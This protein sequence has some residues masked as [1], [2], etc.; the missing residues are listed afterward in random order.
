[1]ARITERTLSEAGDEM[2][3]RYNARKAADKAHSPTPSTAPKPREKLAKVI[4]RAWLNRTWS[5]WYHWRDQLAVI[6]VFTGVA[7]AVARIKDGSRGW[8][9]VKAND[10]QYESSP[11][12][13]PGPIGR[14]LTIPEAHSSWAEEL[15]RF[16]IPPVPRQNTSPIDSL[17]GARQWR[18]HYVA[19]RLT[20][21]CENP[22]ATAWWEGVYRHEEKKKRIEIRAHTFPPPAQRM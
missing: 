22:E 18:R 15:A 21:K 7:F 10:V 19:K 13:D 14:R 3:R 12:H 6:D 5:H 9:P 2:V 16:G 1:M 11:L 8:R 17:R 4:E 20:G